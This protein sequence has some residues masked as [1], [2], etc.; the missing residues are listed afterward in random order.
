MNP[1]AAAGVKVPCFSWRVPPL[2][3]W[4]EPSL[5]KYV[6]PPTYIRVLLLLQA[7]RRAVAALEYRPLGSKRAS[8]SQCEL[9]RLFRRLCVAGLKRMQVSVQRGCEIQP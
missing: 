9:L 6:A 3:S 8:K 7:T 4:K 2:C 5:I 1:L